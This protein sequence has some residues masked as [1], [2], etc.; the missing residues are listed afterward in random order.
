MFRNMILVRLVHKVWIHTQLTFG[1]TIHLWVRI[2]V[3][4]RSYSRRIQVE[5]GL[6]E[7]A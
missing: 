2:W 1:L 4:G 3:V 7:F 6:Q 5:S